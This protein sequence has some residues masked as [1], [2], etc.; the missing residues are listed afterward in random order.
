MEEDHDKGRHVQRR[1]PAHIICEWGQGFRSRKRHRLEHKMAGTS[2]IRQAT[3]G[4][5]R[6]V[7][8]FNESRGGPELPL[9]KTGETGQLDSEEE[10]QRDEQQL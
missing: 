5:W 8:G 2:I 9:T 3:V 6:Q 7:R 10:N 1:T 4:R